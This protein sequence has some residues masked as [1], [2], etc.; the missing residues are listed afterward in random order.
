M[1]VAEANPERLDSVDEVSDLDPLHARDPRSPVR[2]TERV[3]QSWYRSTRIIIEVKAR[4]V[5]DILW[6]QSPEV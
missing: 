1:Q 4:V 6:D 5:G 2:A 3:C